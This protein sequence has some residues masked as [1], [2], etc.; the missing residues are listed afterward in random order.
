MRWLQAIVRSG[1]AV[2]IGVG[3]AVGAGVSDGR[4]VAVTVGGAVGDGGMPVLTT[5]GSGVMV[6]L[7]GRPSTI[8][9][10]AGVAAA[11]E[12]AVIMMTAKAIKH[13][14]L[15]LR[16]MAG[17]MYQTETSDCT[18]L[19]LAK[20]YMATARMAAHNEIK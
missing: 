8:E 10:D 5:T 12:Q 14:N 18:R 9:T 2:G 4:A 1:V 16:N 15:E 3:V 7:D 20:S 19:R 6:G 11:G 17:D 13:M